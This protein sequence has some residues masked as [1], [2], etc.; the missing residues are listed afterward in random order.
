MTGG[1]SDRQPALRAEVRP[2]L[3]EVISLRYTSADL[4]LIE[5]A[6]DRAGE[7]ITHYIRRVTVTQAKADTGTSP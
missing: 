6:A 2:P 4:D 1:V 7:L 3:T 5:A